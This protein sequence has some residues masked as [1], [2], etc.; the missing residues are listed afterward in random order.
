MAST[1]TAGDGGSASAPV[2]PTA[3]SGDPDTATGTET[4]VP[5]ADSSAS[6]TAVKVGAGHGK[7]QRTSEVWQHFE[8]FDPAD[9][10]GRNVRCTVATKLPA[11]GLLGE[12]VLVCGQRFKYRA[13]NRQQ[14]VFGSGTSG[15]LG[16]LRSEHPELLA[17][18]Q[19]GRGTQRA[20]E[21]KAAILL[22]GEVWSFVSHVHSCIMYHA[23]CGGGRERAGH[24][25]FF[26]FS[27]HSTTGRY[28]TPSLFFTGPASIHS[29]AIFF[30]FFFGPCCR[31]C[32]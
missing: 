4:A 18:A 21:D 25:F 9:S 3:S 11:S 6:N 8:L 27:A 17:G 10:Q 2:T 28:H 23:S 14:G 32:V 26:L 19:Q 16:H 12:R 5:V 22:Q 30:F 31:A 29:T 1:P 24:F 13:T 7:R 20:K 15:L